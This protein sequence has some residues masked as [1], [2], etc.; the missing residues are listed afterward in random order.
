MIQTRNDDLMAM[1]L[2]SGTNSM[3]RTFVFGNLSLT[4]GGESKR[5]YGSRRCFRGCE[6]EDILRC[7]LVS[8]RFMRVSSGVTNIRSWLFSAWNP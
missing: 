7:P 3:A 6:L 4:Q 5:V 1:A 2:G 8:R